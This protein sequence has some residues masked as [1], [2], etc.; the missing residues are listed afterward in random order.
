M[1]PSQDQAQV[2]KMTVMNS[3]RDS[4]GLTF[5]FAYNKHW[6]HFTDYLKLMTHQQEGH[7]VRDNV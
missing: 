7:Y 4:G 6:L 1:D 5:S 3:G 2:I